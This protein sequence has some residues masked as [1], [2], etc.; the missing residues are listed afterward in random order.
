MRKLEFSKTTDGKINVSTDG[1]IVKGADLD[2][3]LV[4]IAKR[5]F[6]WSLSMQEL[7]LKRVATKLA[8]DGFSASEVTT[9]VARFKSELIDA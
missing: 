2:L 9:V 4:N 6:Q 1:K 3:K 8:N 7:L 5:Q